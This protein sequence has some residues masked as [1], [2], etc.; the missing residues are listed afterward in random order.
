MY[1]DLVH[2]ERPG[3]ILTHSNEDSLVY[4]VPLGEFCGVH[5]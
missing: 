3:K 4:V 5:P 1:S 2:L